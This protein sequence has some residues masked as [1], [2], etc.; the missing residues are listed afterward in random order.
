VQPDPNQ[1]PRRGNPSSRG[2]RRGVCDSVAQLPLPLGEGWG[3]G[4]LI[5]SLF[6][7]RALAHLS[8][9]RARWELT[10][11][12]SLTISRPFS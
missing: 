9:L 12:S 10:P 5:P 8:Q 11:N 7:R 2:H 6:A 3:E 1:L 4:A